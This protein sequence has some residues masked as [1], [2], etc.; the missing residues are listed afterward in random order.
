MG[1]K[2]DDAENNKANFR[3]V[4]HNI[5]ILAHQ[6][7]IHFVSVRLRLS[8]VVC[9]WLYSLGAHMELSK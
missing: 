9:H 2:G 4:G 5:Y 7:L 8:K 6:V 1:Q 3:E